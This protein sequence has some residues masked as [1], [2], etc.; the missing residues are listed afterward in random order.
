MPPPAK[1]LPKPARDSRS[2]AVRNIQRLL[3]LY[4]FL[5]VVEGALRKW[6]VPQL[7]NPLLLVRDPIAL[8][9]YAL[10][11]RAHIWPRNLFMYF[12]APIA[13]LSWLVAILVLE[14]YV[15]MSLMDSAPT[16]SISRSSSS[17]RKS[18]TPRTSSESAGGFCSA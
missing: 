1:K 17:S 16:F 10:A 7:S 2:N 18:S 3:W 5:L 15:P 9:I 4:I 12:L 8:L 13:L 14:P 6:I 11:I